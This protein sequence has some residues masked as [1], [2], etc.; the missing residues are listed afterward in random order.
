[1]KQSVRCVL[2]LVLCLVLSLSSV[3]A[4]VPTVRA[5]ETGTWTA[6]NTGLTDLDV[7]A[8]AID[9]LTPTTVYAGMYGGGLFR[10][11]DSGISWTAVNTGLAG[12]YILSLAINP[13]TPTTLYA[14]TGDRYGVFRSTDSGTTWTAVNT[15][16][17][18]TTVQCLAINPLTP[19]T[20]YVGTWGGGVFRSSDRGDHWTEVNTGL[21]D[22]WIDSL[23]INP[24][25]S[26]TLYAGTQDGGVFRST[27]SGSTWT[28]ANTGLTDAIDFGI[29]HGGGEV[30]SIAI[31]SLTPTTVYASILA[32]GVFRSMDS[33][34]TWTAVN[35]G[36]PS[37]S[38]D[39][40]VVDPLTPTTLYAGGWGV[41]RSMDSGDNWTAMNT[42]LTE[43]NVWALAINPLTPATLYAGTYGGGVFRYDAASSYALTIT[44]SPSVGGI[45]TKSPDQPTYAPGAVVTLTASAN[46]GYTFTGWSGDLAGTANPTT[47]T[48]DADKTVTAAFT[49]I[50]YGEPKST[51]TWLDY[52]AETTD[53]RSYDVDVC[54]DAFPSDPDPAWLYYFAIQTDFSDGGG[55][56]H[57]GLQW[58]SGGQKANWG[59]YDLRWTGDTQS[60][61]VDQPWT[62]GTWYRY[63]VA[64][65]AQQPDNTW[66]WGF[67]ITDL[68]TNTQHYLGDIY[69]KGSSI[70]GCVVW[71]ETGY[72]VVATTPRA[73]VRWRNP[74]YTYGALQTTGYPA[75]GYATYN[76]TCIEPHTTDQYVVSANPRE[77]VQLTNASVRTIPA[78]TYL[79]K[80]GTF[81]LTTTPSPSSGGTVTK[82][83]DQPTYAPGTVVTLTAIPATGYTFT[84]WSGAF[85]GT[86]NPVIITMD[87]DKT[88]TATFTSSTTGS[89]DANG[90]GTVN[91]LDVLLAARAAAGLGTPLTGSAFQAADVNHDGTMNA[92]DV[93]LI[94][95][96]AV[97]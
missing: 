80:D 28:A 49:A 5:A 17:T 47:V 8:L 21:T 58:A 81:T 68:T 31:N 94:A 77:W 12:Q 97:H 30:R 35:T 2:I 56:A 23:A 34:I 40:I 82:S 22:L 54:I 55:G 65:G 83:P 75:A 42:G 4:G 37:L 88:V 11:M 29:A 43:M 6:V 64:R 96:I 13:L 90:D 52:P 70:S 92:L 46:P 85:N 41:S 51:H 59:G 78:N 69:S 15:G 76:G 62:T 63:H 9:P 26:S 16:L 86:T 91:T 72:G 3:L 33:G 71:M 79:W 60:I 44:A 27:D 89:G 32:G 87:A 95:Q 18:H 61:V 38:A 48:M 1:M 53:V 36:L 67:W 66:A 84:S 74:G 20:L 45:I 93:L 57:G 7:S 24:V 19:T 10:S 73:Q 25:T 14:A 39:P 50:D